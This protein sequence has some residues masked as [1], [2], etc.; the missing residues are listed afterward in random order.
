[1]AL[2][3]MRAD[4]LWKKITI[5]DTD[6][7]SFDMSKVEC[8]NCHK[9]GHFARECRG[10]R[11]Q[12]RGKREDYKQ[13]SKEEEPAPKALMAIDEVGWDWSY[14]ANEEEN[15]ALVADNKAPTEFALMAKSSSSSKNET[16]IVK[17]ISISPHNSVHEPFW[18][19][20][21]QKLLVQIILFNIY[22]HELKMT[23][24][25]M[26]S[27]KGRA[28]SKV[29]LAFKSF[30]FFYISSVVIAT[31]IPFF[32]AELSLAEPVFDSFRGAWI[33]GKGQLRYMSGGN[34]SSL[35]V[36][37]Y[38][39][40]GIF[41]T[42]S[43]NDLSILF[44]TYDGG[45][46]ILFRNY[47]PPIPS[48]FGTPMATK[49]LD[50]DLSGTPVN[51]T[52]YHSMVGA[53]MYLTTSRPDIVHA[54][55]YCGRYQAKPTEKHLTAVKQI[56][57]YLKDT[58]HMG[59]WYPKDTGGDKLVSWSSKKKDYTSMSSIKAEYVS[60]STCYAQVLWMRTQLTDY[61]FHFDKIPMYCDSKASIA[62]SCNPV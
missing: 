32:F 29:V 60:L 16:Q 55:C 25:D 8:F 14:M 20:A 37:K 11:S 18:S 7:A 1:M 52:K 56:F 36:A 50:A 17:I 41:I 59:L 4:R 49:H 10:P 5:H 31:V 27:V 6:V 61:C 3:S 38:S 19:K 46:E 34:T 43:G 45:A 44:P 23:Y 30:L 33:L 2:L 15:H 54:T 57:W 51:Q 39:S 40:C 13:G 42:G 58:I 24:N 48:S 53:L 35:A 9:I 28:N 22:T 21:S 62:I 47:D 26:Q 12:D